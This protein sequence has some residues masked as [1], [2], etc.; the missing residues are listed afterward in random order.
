[1][2]KRFFQQR[3]A[4]ETKLKPE[5]IE[6]DN[7]LTERAAEEF[8]DQA[9][10]ATAEVF[11]EVSEIESSAVPQKAEEAKALKKKASAVLASFYKKIRP[12]VLALPFAMGG[13]YIGYA[14]YTKKEA[15]HY[16][17]G[18][19]LDRG[20]LPAG[21]AIVDTY[22]S[23]DLVDTYNTC[24]DFLQVRKDGKM[25][26]EEIAFKEK[27]AQRMD[28]FS[29]DGVPIINELGR[30]KQIR[31]GKP[32]YTKERFLEMKKDDVPPDVRYFSMMTEIRIDMFRKYLGL[33]QYFDTVKPARYRPAQAKDSRATYAEFDSREIIKS[34]INPVGSL[35]KDVKEL[36]N[37]VNFKGKTFGDLVEF[38]KKHKRFP[39]NS[40]TRQLGKYK[41]DIGFD[42]ERNEQY[43]SYYDVWDMDPPQLKMLGIDVDQ[44][45]FPYE[46]YG[47]IYEKEFQSFIAKNK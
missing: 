34:I 33:E 46:V 25:S 10:A 27:M 43:V 6:T 38:I 16:N 40:Y 18:K 14:H 19:H 30:L 28:P 2:E 17:D 24:I 39:S 11:Q 42:K 1:M 22:I 35:E 44:F 47:R 20:K 3:S 7:K 23:S 32:F 9:L 4:A 45:N 29:Y 41:A 31:E 8:F 26:P 5:K 37:G 12:V 21:M 36:G 15:T 13:S